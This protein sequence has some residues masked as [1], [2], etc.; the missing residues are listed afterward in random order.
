MTFFEYNTPQKTQEQH[1][2]R[3]MSS[4]DDDDR[5]EERI[6]ALQEEASMMATRPPTRSFFL[7]HHYQR[8]EDNEEDN[9]DWEML[10]D[11]EDDSSLSD[12]EGSNHNFSVE[13]ENIAAARGTSPH[14]GFAS[15]LDALETNSLTL[16]RGVHRSNPTTRNNSDI[17]G[18]ISIDDSQD[19]V[20]YTYT[21][22]SDDAGE[23]NENSRSRQE[24]SRPRPRSNWRRSHHRRSISSRRRLRKSSIVASE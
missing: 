5:E 17:P 10:L 7:D 13:L 4:M 1:P 21:M 19:F 22:P 3:L 11:D 16:V 20:D 2:V 6:S 23:D 9:L 18:D 12:S 14:A 8:G 15:V 24:S